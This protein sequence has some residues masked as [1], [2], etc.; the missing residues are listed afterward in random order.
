MTHFGIISPPVSGHIHP[1]SALGRELQARGHRVTCFQMQDL[2]EK[3]QQ[4]GIGFWPIGESDHPLG[5]LPRSLAELGRRKGMAA[6]RFTIQAVARTSVMVCRDGPAAIREAGVEVLLV[7]QME[8][9]GGAVAEHLQLPFLTI[10]NALAINRDPLV[11][12]P[13]SPWNYVE[14]GW[15]KLRNKIGYAVADRITRPIAAAVAGYRAQWK[16]PELHST[17]QSFSKLAQICQMPREF[18]FPRAQLPDCFHY[19]GPLRRRAAIP[20]PFPWDRLDGRPLVY[21]SLGTLQNSREDVFRCIAEACGGLE[22]QLVISHGGGLSAQQ[23]SGLPGDPVVVGYA[24]Q[25]ELL[26]RARLTITHAGLNTVLDSLA[27]GVPLVT[28]PI[29]YEQ[30][31]IARRVEWTGCGRTVPLARLS[32]PLLKKVVK[33]VLQGEKYR[34]ASRRMS[35]SIHKA[36]GVQR[37]ADLIEAALGG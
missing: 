24:P 15:A 34:A 22:V 9:A 25:L 1:F 13:F 10:C 7:D 27:N 3:I 8:P 2:A 23:S 32:V 12:P 14:S 30:P 6:L 5:S 20:A 26:E 35:D 17:D 4:E 21:A 11:P 33:D 29:T 28:V 18:D 31:A 37:A 19:V 16:L 36:G